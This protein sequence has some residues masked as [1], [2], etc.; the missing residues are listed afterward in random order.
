MHKSALRAALAGLAT[1]CTLL[2]TVQPAAAYTNSTLSTQ[3]ITQDAETCSSAGSHGGG[4]TVSSGS[5]AC[6]IDG[7]DYFAS[8]KDDGYSQNAVL[9]LRSNGTLVGLVEFEAYGEHLY[10]WDT[11]DDGD[12]FY[13]WIFAEGKSSGQQLLGPFCACQGASGWDEV[14]ENLDLPEDWQ[15]DLIITDD[16]AGNDVLGSSKPADF[17][18]TLSVPTLVG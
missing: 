11:A 10:V 16:K 5:S 13:V 17:G 18:G 7:V 4:F 1:L 15:A 8:A 14:Y 6:Y 12:G 9:A 2:V 3:W